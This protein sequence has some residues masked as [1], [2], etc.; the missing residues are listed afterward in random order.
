[1]SVV[2][3]GM[4]AQSV[5]L[6]QPFAALPNAT[7]LDTYGD[8]FK[9]WEKPNLDDT[10]P[11]VVIRVGLEG[12]ER[13]ITMA[14]QMLGLYMGTQTAVEAIDR[15]ADNELLFLVPKRA[16]HIEI[17]CGD[18][19]ARLTIMDGT[20]A[21][22]S[23]S[24]YYGS[25]HYIALEDMSAMTHT[26]QKFQLLV[27]PNNALTEVFVNG[28]RE[29]WPTINGVA[30]K[31][32]NHGTYRY[33][34][35]ADRYY[36]QEGTFFVSP[37]STEIQI[38]LRPQFGWAKII[39]DTHLNGAHVFATNLATEQ[40]MQLGTIPIDRAELATGRYMLTFLLD[41]YKD[42][43]T[44]VTIQES[45]VTE[46]YPIMQPNY[47][48]VTLNASEMADIYVDGQRVGKG[49]WKGT[50]EY[51]EYLVETQQQNHYPAYTT[52]SIVQG[53]ANVAYTLNNPTPMY[54]T[55]IVDGRPF[56]AHIFIDNTSMGT[57]PMVFNQILVGEHKVRITKNGYLDNEQIVSIEEG[58]DSK[59]SYTLVQTDQT[60]A[61][62][63]SVLFGQS[64]EDVHIFDLHG[65]RFAM[66][67]VKGGTFIMGAT[68]EQ[69]DDMNSNEIPIHQVTVSDFY[70]AQTEVTQALWKAVMGT[71]PSAFPSN[72]A[73]PVE[74][75]SWADCQTFISKLNA[76]TGQ[77]FRLPTEAEWE[78]AARGGRDTVNYKYAGDSH[79][80]RVA[81][82]AENSESTTHIVAMK[83]PN[84][85]GLYDM[86]G[87]VC[88]WCQDWYADY[89][90]SNQKNPQGPAN[91][92]Y[93]VY[94]GGSWYFDASY[95]RVSQRNY[96]T[97]TFSNYNIGLRLALTQ[98]VDKQPM[99]E[100]AEASQPV[101]PPMMDT[102]RIVKVGDVAFA[103]V[104]VKGGEF[105]MG[106]TAEQGSDAMG[107]ER[108]IRQITLS[109]Y[110]ISQTEVTQALWCEVMGNNPSLDTTH[111]LKPVT[112]VS[113]ADCQVFI[114]KL[115]ELTGRQ[116]RLPTEAEWEYAARGGR[117]TKN[118]KYAGGNTPNDIAWHNANSNGKTN[119]IGQKQPNE[120]GL[121]DM[122][123]NVSEWCHDWFG[124]YEGDNLNNPQGP[125]TGSYR[126]VRGGSAQTPTRMQR[127][128]YRNGYATTDKYADLGFR[129]VEESEST[130][131]KK[132]KK[133]EIPMHESTLRFNVKGVVFS[134]VKVES[135]A[136]IMGAT[137]EHQELAYD[138][139]KPMHYVT[140]S[141]FFIG[142]TEVTQELWK[143]VMDS[144]PC[145]FQNDPT[146][147]V[148][149]VSW[150]DCQIFI[151]KLNA[152]TGASFRLP[153]EAEWEYAA[154][155]GKKTQKLLYAGSN[156]VEEVVWY[157]ENS[158]GTSHPVGLKQPNEIG[159]YDM[160]G[161][162]WEWC[163]DWYGKYESTSQINPQ[164]PEESTTNRR[165]IRGGSWAYDANNCRVPVRNGQV[166]TE[167]K[168][169]VG[170]RLAL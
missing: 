28:K 41:K 17:T 127:V 136:F 145:H 29:F 70:M 62:N 126:V 119:P 140:L 156:N 55:L 86:S 130:A 111:I 128:S 54:G 148:E 66:V 21:L 42:Y 133:F 96:H 76:L 47:S 137:V 152:L 36:P 141:D 24:I 124:T 44:T 132:V 32:I 26:R 89:E 12:N 115:N 45:Q 121:Y 84:Q 91:G 53:D 104:E 20:K 165:I 113:W 158:L 170:F 1:M 117:L 22:Q 139:E 108:P 112:N 71:N 3:L 27:S 93:K 5:T 168:L 23:N 39:A 80:Q 67:K 120:L 52:V 166:V 167:K 157:R 160:S 81:W 35:S 82:S 103:M 69:R 64:T 100:V 146:N 163:Q 161:N 110:T 164:G 154:R 114:T 58:K 72:S 98:L 11:Y 4:W 10:F 49:T 129:L 125:P 56:D 122:S 68:E 25:I 88:E 33:R 142:Q 77:T 92:S 38:S 116:F 147:P 94:R 153:T 30:S 107:G 57:T 105:M 109:D 138:W 43:T 37:Q 87:N 16:R 106:A 19:C 102:T 78:Y 65:V 150:E 123:G 60:Q 14:R 144:V 162:V 143:A 85:L 51:G 63:A 118:T 149:N 2:S 61:L 90:V 6:K 48:Q 83:Q 13:D 151:R 95:A 75:V 34:V 97:T 15:S 101:A 7:V 73:N 31:I 134:M 159:I 8:K 155:G 79:S 131:E 9:K 46:V 99:Q 18:G 40:T 59:L 50:L 169:D 74:N 135:G